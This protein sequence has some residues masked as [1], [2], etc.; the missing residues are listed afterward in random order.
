MLDC[1]RERKLGQETSCIVSF[2]SEKKKSKTIYL[3]RTNLVRFSERIF[4]HKSLTMCL[5]PYSLFSPSQSTSRLHGVGIV[6]KNQF[7]RLTFM[8]YGKT[9]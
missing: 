3:A 1:W 2:L 5:V 6:R 7:P 4:P 9:K 8:G